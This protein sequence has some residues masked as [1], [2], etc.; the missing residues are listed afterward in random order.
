MHTLLRIF[1]MIMG[2]SGAFAFQQSLAAEKENTMI[3][4]EPQ[5]LQKELAAQK[6]PFLLDV[7][8]PAE[9]EAGHIKGATLIPLGTLPDRLNEIPKD[10][11]VVVYCRS[12]HRSSRAIEFL[13]QHGFEN[14]VNLTGGMNAWAQACSVSNKGAC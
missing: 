6:T 5:D 13:K 3:T 2:L 12:G 7:R 8:E 10:R 1:L 14:V 11:R 9:F 4:I